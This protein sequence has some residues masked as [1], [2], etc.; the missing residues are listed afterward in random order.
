MGKLIFVYV[1]GVK[2]YFILNRVPWECWDCLEEL[3]IVETLV[4]WVSLDHMEEHY[5]DLLVL[6][7]VGD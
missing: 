3:G 6:L 1:K 5:M 4:I 2:L 7:D